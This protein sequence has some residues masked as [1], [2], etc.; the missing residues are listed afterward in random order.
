MSRQL[1]SRAFTVVRFTNQ[2]PISRLVYNRFDKDR[3]LH[4]MRICLQVL[5]E[6][7]YYHTDELNFVNGH[8]NFVQFWQQWTFNATKRVGISQQKCWLLINNIFQQSF[9]S[10]GRLSTLLGGLLTM[11]MTNSRRKQWV[12]SKLLS[13]SDLE[14]FDI[15]GLSLTCHFNRVPYG[16]LTL[17]IKC[18]LWQFKFPLEKI[19]NNSKEFV[20][21]A[22]LRDNALGENYKNFIRLCFFS[23]F[24]CPLKKTSGTHV[25]HQNELNTWKTTFSLLYCLAF[26]GCSY[27]TVTFSSS[28]VSDGMPWMLNL[29]NTPVIL[30]NHFKPLDGDQHTPG[31]VCVNENTRQ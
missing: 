27:K 16:N 5:I 21:S 12:Y 2:N 1:A 28:F 13:K 20:S 6:I 18:S 4:Q 31:E 10:R 22:L 7:L 30:Q 25:F 23:T 24:I 8:V 9:T 14:Q 15:Y 29:Q 19:L 11:L 17:L 3:N 26:W